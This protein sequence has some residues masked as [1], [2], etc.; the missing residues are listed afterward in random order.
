MKPTDAELA[1][2]QILWEKG[3]CP[4]RVVNDELRKHKE[5][6]Y[7]TTLKLMQ[8]MVEKG[9]AVRDTR[10]RKHIYSASIPQEQTQKSLLDKIANLAFGGSHVQ[11]AMRALGDDDISMEELQELKELIKNIEKRS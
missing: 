9:I 11:L 3:P 5:V 10:T 7:T 2:L 6:G 1:I 8:I 4:V